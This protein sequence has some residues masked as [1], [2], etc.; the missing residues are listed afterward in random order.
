MS[1]CCAYCGGAPSTKDHVPSRILLD[2]PYDKGSPFVGACMACNNGLSQAETY[3][4]CLIECA[5]AGS[6]NVQRVSRIK[7]KQALKR[8]AKL[9]AQLASA[10]FESGGRTYFSVDHAKVRRV[11]LKLARGHSLFELNETCKSEPTYF[12]Y[13]ALETMS[14]ENR[15]RFEKLQSAT[16][17]PEVNCRAMQ[18]LIILGNE[19]QPDWLVV[20]RGRYRY[21]TAWGVGTVVVRIVLSEYLACEAIWLDK[22]D[23]R[24]F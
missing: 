7:V 6:A 14:E 16:L 8:S 18:R 12:G 13:C 19:L 21:G 22:D 20:Q 23:V 1:A 24:E 17:W 9:A 3:V 10:R 15:L 2:K 5:L 4:A 11:L